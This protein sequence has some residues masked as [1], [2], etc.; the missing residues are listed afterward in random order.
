MSFHPTVNDELQ[1]DGEHYRVAEHP[2][3]PGIPYGQEGRRAVV[4]QLI[5]ETRGKYALK[6]FKSRFRVPGMVSV[7]ESL[8]PYANIPGLQACERVVLTA[9]RHRSLLSEYPDLTY[10]VLMPWVEGE[11]WQEI[12]LA[13]EASS[14]QQLLQLAKNFAEILVGLEERRLAHCDLSGPNVIIQQ[15]NQIGFVD[16]EEMYGPGFLEPKEIPAGSPG[17]AHQSA[18]R[19]LWTEEADRFA[20][21]VLLAEMLCW[22]DPHVRK[23][24]WGESYFAP[25]DMQKVNERYRVLHKALE[26]LYDNRVAALFSQAWRS[27]SLDDCPTFAEWAVA[28]PEEIKTLEKKG[29]V[30]QPQQKQEPPSGK[31]TDFLALLLETAPKKD[32]RGEIEE[33]LSLYRQAISVAPPDLSGEIEERIAELEDRLLKIKTPPPREAAAR[34]CLVCGKLIL[35][36]QEICPHCEGIPRPS[37][38]EKAK[39]KLGPI[40]VGM[41]GI[42][43]IVLG[44]VFVSQGRKGLA[45]FSSLTTNTPF[46]DAT[47]NITSTIT[48]TNTPTYTLKP[49]PLI[50]QIATLTPTMTSSPTLEYGIGSTQ[51]SEKDGMILVYVPAGEFQMGSENGER[52]EEPVHTVYLDAFWIDQTEVTNALFTKFINATSYVTQAEREGWSWDYDGTS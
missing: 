22:S 1:I 12:L 14:P 7:A 8:I 38:V 30:A 46:P 29:G 51:V 20:G 33:A 32:Q 36:G 6:V 41:M 26:K 52:D 42:I 28:I 45:L 19:G 15:E 9:L 50:T 18:P 25:K 21:A 3:A 49:T 13:A 31:E 5:A 4:Y 2:A 17:Y 44:I 23:A 27:D 35:V 34:T 48:R 47:D 24:A 11:T 16:L 10:A 43:L 37:E 40:I 39:F